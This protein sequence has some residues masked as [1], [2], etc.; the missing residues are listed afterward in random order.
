MNQRRASELSVVVTCMGRLSFLTR[1]LPAVLESV[2]GDYCLVDYSCPDRCA[3][4]VRQ[5]YARECEAGRIR[6]AS[7]PGRTEF[8]RANARNTGARLAIEAGARFI[9]F[10]D[11]DTRPLSGFAA[12]VSAESAADR[13]LISLGGSSLTGFLVVPAHTF[14]R[15]GGFDEGIADYGGEDIELRLRLYLRGGLA[16]VSA[17]PRML[18]VAPH[19]DELRSRFHGVKDIQHSNARNLARVR[20]LVREWTGQEIE[21]ASLDVRRLYHTE[22]TDPVTRGPAIALAR[23]VPRLGAATP[24]VPPDQTCGPHASEDE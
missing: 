7:V 20:A 8:H 19:S 9:C 18:A 5:E 13:F 1:T 23:A 2:A 16:Y 10:L 17:P 14:Q 11:A 24:R 6:I 3:E 21:E 15:L 4:W 12:W 22:F